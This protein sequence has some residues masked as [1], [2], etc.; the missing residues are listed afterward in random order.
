MEAETEK[1]ITDQATALSLGAAYGAITKHPLTTHGP[2]AFAAAVGSAMGVAGAS[3]AG[4]GGTLSAGA[5]VIAAKAAVVATV[6]AAVF[7]IV[8]AAGAGFGLYKLAK[9]LTD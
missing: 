9:K 6:G 3:G 5:T 8:L 7:P 2:G 1:T 4:I